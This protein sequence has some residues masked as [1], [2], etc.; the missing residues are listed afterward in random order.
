MVLAGED[1]LYHQ[2]DEEEQEDDENSYVLAEN[3]NNNDSNNNILNND[4][5]YNNNIVGDDNKNAI[6]N[7]KNGSDEDEKTK[8]AVDTVEK[9]V[10]HTKKSP[11]AITITIKT[12][13]FNLKCKFINTTAIEIIWD[14]PS[15]A[16]TNNFCGYVIT[17]API[18]TK[19][20][21]ESHTYVELDP[22]KT[23]HLVTDLDYNLPYWFL[24]KMFL[25]DG[26]FVKESADFLIASRWFE[27]DRVL[28][29]HG[30]AI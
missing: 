26:M 20:N 15:I 8:Y 9:C 5:N 27:H 3:E 13:E 11:S 14:E 4:K 2:Q 17:W 10:D 16:N 12:L 24:V 19:H 28:L 21:I 29:P 23:C 18:T 25:N 6:N 7:D 1:L 22:N 30:L